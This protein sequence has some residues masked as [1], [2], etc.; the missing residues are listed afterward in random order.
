[1][2]GDVSVMP[3]IRDIVETVL[4]K[5]DADEASVKEDFY[6]RC[7]SQ[8]L[9]CGRSGSK[10]PEKREAMNNWKLDLRAGTS[11]VDE[12]LE[13]LQAIRA[14]DPKAQIAFGPKGGILFTVA[15][16]EDVQKALS[17]GLFDVSDVPIG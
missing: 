5:K 10:E 17:T 1:M 14:L 13:V 6:T 8:P 11:L 15:S 9:C 12:W 3:S 7:S 2:K 16:L 4:L